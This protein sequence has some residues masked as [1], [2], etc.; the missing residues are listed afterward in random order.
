MGIFNTLPTNIWQAASDLYWSESKGTYIVIR[1]MDIHHLK[2]SMKSIE[3]K[4][5]SKIDEFQVSDAAS[6][7]KVMAQPAAERIAYL[8]P[9]YRSLQ[10]E[11]N[12]RTPPVAVL[13][14]RKLI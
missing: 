14:H 10:E 1:D 6:Y 3:S 7:Q 4:A 9:L 8:V 12:R 2:N 13:K 5:L 11:L